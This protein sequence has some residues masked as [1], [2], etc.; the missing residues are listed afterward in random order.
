MIY[1][2]LL[3]LVTAVVFAASP[4]QG[5]LF[6]NPLAPEQQQHILAVHEMPLN[7]RYHNPIVSDV[8]KD[9]ILLTLSYFS[10]TTKQGEPVN[11]DTVRKPFTYDLVINPGEVFTF[12]DAALPEY[13]GKKI[14]TTHVHYG[15]SDGFR[16]DGYLYGDGVCHLASLMNWAAK[17]AGLDVVAPTNHDFA[18]IPDVPKQYGVA[19]YTDGKNDATSQRENLYIENNKDKPVHFVFNYQDNVLKVAVV[20]E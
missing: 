8:F 12:Q 16:S 9:N 6:A 18:N 3:S 1:E 5:N 11:W 10:G 17:D 15:A 19:I 20:E 4:V 14:T 13:Q 2:K 7:D